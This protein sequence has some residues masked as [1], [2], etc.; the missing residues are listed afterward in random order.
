M[1][2]RRYYHTPIMMPRCVARLIG[3]RHREGLHDVIVLN[4]R[5]LHRVLV[6]SVDY[7]HTYRVPLVL[8]H[9]RCD[10]TPLYPPASGLFRMLSTVGV[11]SSMTRD[12]QGEQ[13]PQC[14]TR[15]TVTEGRERYLL[16][17]DSYGARTRR[18]SH[19]REPTKVVRRERAKGCRAWPI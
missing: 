10:S 3:S 14:L 2:S 8:R 17:M 1:L 16:E 5:Y 18:A 12:W 6:S 7:D 4:A 13:S 19:R 15:S 11:F 9:G